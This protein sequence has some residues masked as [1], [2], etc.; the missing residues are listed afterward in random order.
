MKKN[1]PKIKSNIALADKINAIEGIVSTYFTDGDYTPYYSERG[2]IIAI[3]TYFIDG[4]EFE[5]NESVYNS[6]TKDDEVMTLIKM[7][8]NNK[9]NA[10][11][12]MSFVKEQVNDK[13]NFA[14]EQIIHNHADMDKIIEFCNVVIDSFENF[15]KLNLS[16]ISQEDMETGL[17]IMRQLSEKDFSKD[18]IAD[19]IKKAANF[20]MDKATAEIVDAKNAEI[21][22]L[23][24][25]KTLW[26][27]RNVT[28]DNNIIPMPTKE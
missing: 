4:L 14:K 6:V 27:S 23:K 25:Y 22:E 9:S 13:V 5:E 20:D 2:E 8:Y 3:A 24:K 1:N 16:Q 11:K 28:S 17:N 19:V 26:E 15:S 7:F 12:V 21:R 18:D 10:F